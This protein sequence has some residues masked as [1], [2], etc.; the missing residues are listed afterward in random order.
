MARLYRLFLL[1]AVRLIEVTEELVIWIQHQ[2]IARLAQRFPIG[3]DR[4]IKCIKLCIFGISFG[5]N[6]GGSRIALTANF[7]AIAVRIGEQYRTIL[8]RR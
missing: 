2:N 8:V 1:N 7:L 5:I 4:T 3:V 6:L